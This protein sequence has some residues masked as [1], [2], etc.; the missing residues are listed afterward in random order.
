MT[1]AER[2]FAADSAYLRGCGEV[3]DMLDRAWPR[4]WEDWNADCYDGSIEVYGVEASA[5]ALAVL[6]EAGFRQTWIHGHAY[7]G[8]RSSLLEGGG[9]E[10]GCPCFDLAT[11]AKER[12]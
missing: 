9:G 8:S 2:Y 1:L 11:D 3:V 6:A 7:G 4:G 10:C 12:R 5:A